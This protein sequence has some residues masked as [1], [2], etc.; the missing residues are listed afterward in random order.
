MPAAA[1][2]TQ[3]ALAWHARARHCAGR[4]SGG[5]AARKTSGRAPCRGGCG[6][7]MFYARA[8]RW[9]EPS[10]LQ[11]AGV[12]RRASCGNQPQPALNGARTRAT[13]LADSREEAHHASLLRARAVP[14]CLWSAHGLYK[15]TAPERDLSLSARGRGATC[16]LR[17]PTHSLLWRG[18]RAR[19]TALIISREEVQHASF[20]S[21]R[22]AAVVV[23][24]LCPMRGHRAGESPL[25]F[26]A[27]PWCDVPAVATNAHPALA[28]RAHARQCAGCLP[29]GGAARDLYARARRA[30]LI[31]VGPWLL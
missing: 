31:V 19:A 6:R 13:E 15:G 17:P 4:L 20:L 5:R 18:T 30:A 24:G 25:S 8:L 3:P 16:H 9:R 1:T 26:S 28:W 10:L 29:G 22:R 7:P 14:R 21:A 12:V 27:R 2:S 23:V 11:H